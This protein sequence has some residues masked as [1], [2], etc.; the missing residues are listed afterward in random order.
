MG[1]GL[2]RLLGLLAA[3]LRPCDNEASRS[4]PAETKIT[5]SATL[6]ILAGIS[7]L[8]DRAPPTSNR[9]ALA[10][11][12]PAAAPVEVLRRGVAG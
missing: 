9:S 12:R 2:V 6:A 5:R 8:V 4:L 7:Y 10:I 1:P 3:E 11:G